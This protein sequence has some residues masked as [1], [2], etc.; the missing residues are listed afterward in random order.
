[1]VSVFSLYSTTRKRISG[2]PS[3]SN[4]SFKHRGF[5]LCDSVITYWVT[6]PA[7]QPTKSWCILKAHGTGPLTLETL[8]RALYPCWRPKYPPSI[9]GSDRTLNWWNMRLHERRPCVKYFNMIL[10]D[11]LDTKSSQN[12]TNVDS[13]SFILLFSYSM[14]CHHWKGYTGVQPKDKATLLF[15]YIGA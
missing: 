13:T 11:G 15:I 1:M 2:F 4:Y 7:G 8:V 12:W 3:L 6:W 14:D 5:C 9:K 10:Y